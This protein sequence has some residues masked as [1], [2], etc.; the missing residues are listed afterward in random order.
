MK[1]HVDLIP[2]PITF[3]L[4]LENFNWLCGEELR[5]N[6]PDSPEVMLIYLS[7]EWI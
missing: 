1:R 6:R 3:N 4:A 7:M 2:L 5:A